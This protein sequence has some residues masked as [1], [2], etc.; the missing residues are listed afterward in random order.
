MIHRRTLILLNRIERRDYTLEPSIYYEILAGNIVA[1]GWRHLE[2][3]GTLD[4][5]IQPL[6]SYP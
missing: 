6:S 4:F 1:F 3:I 2:L 5:Y